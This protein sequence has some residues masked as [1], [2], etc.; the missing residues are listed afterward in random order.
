MGFA[1]P[2][3][4]EGKDKLY[5]T[6][7]IA[8]VVR[9]DGSMANLMIEVTGLN[10]DKAEKWYVENRW[11]PAV[12]AGRTSTDTMNAFSRNRQRHPEHQGQLTRSE[13]CK[14]MAKKVDSINTKVLELISLRKRRLV[15]KM[16]MNK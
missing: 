7:F 6:D 16:P 5:F 4:K 3:V 13:H 9:N 14:T 11:I 15:M 8:R 2:Y 10:T 1:I 12:N